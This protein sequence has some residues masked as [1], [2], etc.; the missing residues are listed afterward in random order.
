MLVSNSPGLLA[1]VGLTSKTGEQCHWTTVGG[2]VTN[3][4]TYGR[5]AGN[6]HVACQSPSFPG[7]EALPRLEQGGEWL[8]E[9]ME[10]NSSLL[11]RMKDFE[12]D[13]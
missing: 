8:T 2:E 10:N 3:L 5:G 1:S 13:T 9:Q 12:G 7:E 4:S 11:V 6:A